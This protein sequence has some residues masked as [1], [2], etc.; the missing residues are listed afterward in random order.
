MTVMAFPHRAVSP[1][2]PEE[3]GQLVEMLPTALSYRSIAAKLGRS[4]YQVGHAAAP[5]VEL[6]KATG[7]LPP[8]ACGAPRFH[9]FACT[10]RQATQSPESRQ[11]EFPGHLKE[12]YPELMLRREIIVS[13]LKAGVRISEIEAALNLNRG[14]V[15][16][17]KR[18]LTPADMEERER[19]LAEN[20]A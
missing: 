16:A 8:C 17:Y 20:R 9:R 12:R 13:M 3:M 10:A 18:F 6:M 5:V 7:S 1:L 4:R 2:S 19:I 11:R 15:K 14:I